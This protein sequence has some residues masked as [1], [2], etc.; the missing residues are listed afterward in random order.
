MSTTGILII[1]IIILLLF[2]VLLIG[3]IM[4]LEFFVDPPEDLKWH[5]L[6]IIKKLFGVD[7]LIK[8]NY[9][10]SLIGIIYIVRILIKVII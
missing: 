6:S 1:A 2:L 9:T 10:L 7:F 4:K 3:T 8:F 5:S